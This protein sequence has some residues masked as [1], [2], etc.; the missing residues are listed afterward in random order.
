MTEDGEFT[1]DDIEK[2][3]M[4]SLLQFERL[5]RKLHELQ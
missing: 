3:F 4:R 2:A 1:Y 5:F